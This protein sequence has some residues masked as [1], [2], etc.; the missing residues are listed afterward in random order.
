MGLRVICLLRLNQLGDSKSVELLG[1]WYFSIHLDITCMYAPNLQQCM[2]V[3]K[4]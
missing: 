2:H 3:Y 1:V 4:Q